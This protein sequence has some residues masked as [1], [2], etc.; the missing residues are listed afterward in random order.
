VASA[1]TT[2]TVDLIDVITVI[3]G[4]IIATTIGI[5]VITTATIAVMTGAM[6][7]ITISATIGTTTIGVTAATTST[8][9]GETIDVAKM[10][11]TATTTIGKNGLHCHR[12]KG[13]TP[14]VCSSLP[15]ERSTSSSAVAKRPKATDIS[16]QTQGRSGMSTPKPRSLC[17][18]P[19]S[20]SLS[21]GRI[22]G[23]TSPTPGHTRWSLT[24]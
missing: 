4:P 1:L 14:M 3:T 10:T 17:V 24:L 5:D 23:S 7:T 12:L 18:D 9:T 21:P 13:A 15:T 16:N 20:Q 8:T 22:I 2:G 19:S 11:I 6:T